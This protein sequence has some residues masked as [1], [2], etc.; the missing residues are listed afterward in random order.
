ME[1]AIWTMASR[2]DVTLSRRTLSC[3]CF[4]PF[5][6]SQTANSAIN[7]AMKGSSGRSR[8][9]CWRTLC[10]SFPD[11]SVIPL[12]AHAGVAEATLAARALPESIHDLQR[13]LHDREQDQLGDPVARLDPERLAA[14]VPDA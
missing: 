1:L 14:A 8:A 7:A 4:Q 6:A 10:G 2:V 5:H 9:A 3:I 13:G 11:M 12:S